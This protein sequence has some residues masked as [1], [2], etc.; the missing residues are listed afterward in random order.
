MALDKAYIVE[1]RHFNALNRAKVALQN[2][3]SAV[4]VFPLDLV[5][6]DIKEAWSDLGEITGETANESIISTVFAK[7]CVGK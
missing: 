2:A 6:I 3:V 1:E 5:A 4:G 7:F